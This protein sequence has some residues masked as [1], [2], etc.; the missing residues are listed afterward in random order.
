MINYLLVLKIKKFKYIIV[1]FCNLIVAQDQGYLWYFGHGA[2][3][4]FNSGS[5][6][7]ISDGQL[8]TEEGCTS[9]S[10]ENG[11]LLFYTDGT[12][13]YNKSHSPMV[14]GTN[15]LGD[16]SATQSSI[17]LKKPNSAIVY[18]V[19]TVGGT[20][21]NQG[22]LCFSEID[23]SLN[24]GLG[25]VTNM[26]NIEILSDASEKVTAILHSNG[27]D[28]WIVAPQYSS[29]SYFSYLVTSSGV[30]STPIQ[31]PI[32]SAG[33]NSIGYLVAS[34]DGTKICAANYS[35]NSLDLF[36]F[37]THTGELSFKMEVTDTT[38]P[39][40]IAFSTNSNVLYVSSLDGYF[41]FDLSAGTN[42]A[43]LN[44]K[45]LINN[46][47]NYNQFGAL[48]L[49][50][51]QKIY[52]V[53]K[54]GE[55]VSSIDYPNLLG[56][57][58]HF[59]QNSLQLAEGQT[60]GI[61]L[62]SF[63]NALYDFSFDI[64]SSAFCF[65]DSTSFYI[66]GD[67]DSVFWDFGD[68]ATGAEN[69]SNLTSPLHQFS[70]PGDYLVTA[71]AVRG[72]FS[73][74][75]NLLVTITAPDSLALNIGNDTILCNG[76][77]LVLNASNRNATYLWQDMSTS[78]SIKVGA[79]GLYFVEV[80]QNV[81]S[82]A[83]SIFIDV[84]N[85]E[86]DLGRDTTLCNDATTLLDP[87]IDS[88]AYVWQDG[89]TDSIFLVSNAGMYW[90]QVTQN[91]CSVA[92]S[93]II[94]VINLDVNLGNDT[95]LCN[96][97]SLVLD[98]S[99]RNAT[100]L[101]QD[102]SNDS[103][104]LVSNAGMY[105][106]KLSQN[107]CSVAD[108]I[109]IEV[110]NLEID[111]GSDTTLCYGEKMLL[112]LTLNS[113][114]YVWQDGSTD[115]TFLVSNEGLYWLKVSQNICSVADSISIAINPLVTA[116]LS[117]EDSTCR[118]V[119]F[120]DDAMISATGKGPFSIELSNGDSKFYHYAAE[121][122]F[123]IPIT[124][125]G[126]YTISTIY[127]S[128]LCIGKV[129]GEAVYFTLPTPNA[130]FRVEAKD[131]FSDLGSVIFKNNSMGQTSSNWS[132]GDDFYLEDNSSMI[133]HSYGD[134]DTYTIQLLVEN[135]IGCRD[136]TVQD[137]VVQSNDYFLP[138]AFTPFDRNNINDYFGLNN[139]RVQG[140]EMKIFDRFGKLVYATDN[141][142]RPWDGTHKGV[143]VLPGVYAYI[144]NL[145]DPT[146]ALRKLKGNVFLID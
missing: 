28:F 70:A 92:D 58:C 112:N 145:I 7:P 36:D 68:T 79:P 25:A 138:N 85:L 52:T 67:V 98:A 115:S 21:R 57:R 130:K 104:F 72:N 22:K 131:V 74:P 90:L 33:Y 26:K 82:I 80:T 134:L 73:Y 108:S 116:I 99:N 14:N 120:T 141:I 13:V 4:D 76:D 19:F 106:V 38:K 16:N 41:Q 129:T 133:C 100:Y 119:P 137:F 10:D 47:A 18:Y 75:S 61:G 118:G 111:L 94:D 95:T 102:G 40:G 107:I 46:V 110:I 59:N 8:N 128:N 9:I 55:Y 31:S 1:L 97:E 89:T 69:T 136:S 53:T 142:E 54:N 49:G 62:P 84:I 93:I 96:D 143:N 139:T 20:S 125:E 91:I 83:D 24:D 127:G 109:R 37:D 23:I 6:V 117:G 50:P 121:N 122:E 113:D 66:S 39:Y 132:F 105:W 77:S 29:A 71:I 126:V 114:T 81:C 65:G 135:D 63:F 56:A 42:T 12:T 101:W 124:E 43:I 64:S 88:V 3:I 123:E 140:F 35:A 27:I 2:G 11:D 60:S 144:I 34:P 86:I 30:N 32:A 44:S 17:I 48:Q 146:G 51:D 78:E 5:P 87:T 15:L 103:K 45:F